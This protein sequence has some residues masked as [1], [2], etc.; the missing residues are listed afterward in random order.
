MKNSLIVAVCI[1]LCTARAFAGEELK[2]VTYVV[3]A[4]K[5]VTVAGVEPVGSTVELTGTFNSNHQMTADKK[6]VFTLSG[7][8]GYVVKALTLKMHSNKSAGAGTFSFTAGKD[9]IAAID[10][11]TTFDK[12]Y[13]MTSY[14]ANKKDVTVA[15]K[16]GYEEGYAVK[17]GQDLT[18]TISATANSLYIYS[19]TISYVRTDGM[20]DAPVIIPTKGDVFNRKQQIYIGC[21]DDAAK[22]YF[23]TDGTE[24]TL[25]ST[26]YDVDVPLYIDRTTTIK[27]FAEMGGIRQKSGPKLLKREMTSRR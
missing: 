24:P 5:T 12:W 20:L 11:A 27:A 4:D 2:S 7:Y 13:N 8:D 16:E 26:V 10:K 3:N 9:V 1:F 23:T 6:A 15:F 14:S 22:I 19:C 17:D 18:I 21:D 25:E